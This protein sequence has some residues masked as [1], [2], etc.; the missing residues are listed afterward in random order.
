MLY[1][2]IVTTVP[3]LINIYIYIYI[4]DGG[5][6]TALTSTGTTSAKRGSRHSVPIPVPPGVFRAN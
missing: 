3:K 6:C 1:L 5:T 4:W 2:Y